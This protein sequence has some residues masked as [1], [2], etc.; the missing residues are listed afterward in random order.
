MIL[1]VDNQLP[2][3]L[4]RHLSAGG[5]ECIHVLDA[6]LEEADDRV[7]WQYEKERNMVIVSKDEDFQACS[8]SFII[9]WIA[10]W[11]STIVSRCR[12]RGSMD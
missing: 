6:G 11:I 10:G 8:S 9:K 1:L 3:A 5:C 12:G 7:I 2:I 4:A